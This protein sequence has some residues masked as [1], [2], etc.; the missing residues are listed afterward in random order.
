[1]ARKKAEKPLPKTMWALYYP[2]G[3]LRSVHGTRDVAMVDARGC[4]YV[5]WES[6]RRA[7]WR[8][9]KVTVTPLEKP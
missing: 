5:T 3:E 6:R 9:V 8:C 4:S 2:G 7:G 1:M